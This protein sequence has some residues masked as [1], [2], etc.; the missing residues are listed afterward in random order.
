[1]QRA[2]A[3][4]VSQETQDNGACVSECKTRIIGNTAY[5]IGIAYAESGESVSTIL[6]NHMIDKH[7]LREP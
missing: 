3:I 5:N 4:T 1:M 2:E 7:K 6:L